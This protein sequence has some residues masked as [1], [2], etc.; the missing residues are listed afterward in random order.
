MNSLRKLEKDS[1]KAE[2]SSLTSLIDQ[3]S[4][5]DL[6]SRLSLEDRLN[7]LRQQDAAL[8][9]EPEEAAASVSLFF[10]G[11]PVIGSRGIESAFGSNI[12]SK[13]QDLV[14]K[15]LA[16]DAGGLG[17]RGIVPNR[18]ASTL[19]ITNVVRGSF[20]FHLEEMQPQMVDT[21]LKTAVEH[22]TQLLD[23]F[24]TESEEDYRSALA[25]AD[26][27]VLA[28]VKDFFELIK[29]NEATVRLVSGRIDSSFRTAEV[30]RAV[31]RATSSELDESDEQFFGVLNGALPQA[32]QFE[33]TPTEDDLI[34]GRI[35]PS[36]AS[37][38]INEWISNAIGRDILASI[39]VKK[40]LRNRNEVRRSYI[41]RDIEFVD[42]LQE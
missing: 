28:S 21:T 3:I 5:D 30:E 25:E 2:I 38:T 4:P 24:G 6:M 8:V 34:R 14:S 40:V 10:G 29:Q 20:G 37:A 36:V 19:H 33:F 18:S 31:E 26:P 7:E 9:D 17:R 13:F 23:A 12:V 41:L 1:L 27:R 39:T 35:D 16:N 22:A 42:N 11:R 15:Q 32:R